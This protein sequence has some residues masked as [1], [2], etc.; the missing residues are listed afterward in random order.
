MDRRSFL[1]SA[2]G[3]GLAGLASGA[4]FLRWQEIT[5]QAHLPGQLEG[6]MLRDRAPLPEPGEVIETD[7]AILGSGI[8]GLSA[9]WQLGRLGHRDFLL[10]DG[11]EA[12]GNAAGSKYGEYACP[13]GAHYLPLPGLEA[14]H[15]RDM[16][17]DLG[18]IQGDAQVEQPVYDERCILHGPHERLL[19]RGSWQD[20]LVPTVG[21]NAD[22]LAQQ[23]RFFDL[24]DSLRRQRGTDGRRAF[25]FPAVLSSNDPAFLE[26]DRISFAA[27]L[28]RE[29]Y[30][31]PSLRWYLD[32]CCR[33]DYGATSER[34][35]AWAGLHY[36]AGRWGQAANA[37]ENALLTWPGGLSPLAEGLAARA[38]ARRRP[39]TAASVRVNGGR[40]EALCFVMEGGKPRSFLVRARRMI[41]AMP[42]FVASRV[43]EDIGALGFDPR[44]H[45]PAYA[46]WMVTNFLMRDFPREPGEM[47]LAWDN[48][49]H[50]G[51]GLGY[52]VSTH[53][54]IR[55]GVP[56]KTV[57]TAYMALS[58][59]SPQEA[60]RWMQQTGPGELLELA[61]A[62]MKQ[63]YGWRLASCVERADIT[64][65]AHA[66]AIPQPGFLANP[67]IAALRDARGPLLFAHSDL[68]GYSV[69][70]E[71]A[72]WGCEAARRA[73]G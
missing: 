30:T 52:V 69:F 47:P 28:D 73:A 49:V 56:E 40:A 19:V 4:G 37:D 18:I 59:R 8:A 22:E 6:H 27:W 35:S 10:F 23:R 64:L 70:E 67:G 25:V 60:R 66:M 26:L 61:L 7:V 58:D 71:A 32:Y 36:F 62:D 46:P 41:C 42:L 9:A 38:G 45:M 57:F 16:L 63:A 29:G 13:T 17:R 39:G 50:G 65:R 53:Q 24:M 33:D 1:I 3:A 34:T 12:F 48:V 51:R 5:P 72:W 2:G 43:V 20:G 11:P 54:D 15:V 44:S 68:S 21:V 55:V 31:A 14:S